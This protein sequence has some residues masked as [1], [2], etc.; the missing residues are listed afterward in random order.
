M[1]TQLGFVVE[2]LA[3]KR[4]GHDLQPRHWIGWRRF[5]EQRPFRKRGVRRGN[6]SAIVREVSEGGGAR[7]S[8]PVGAPL[9]GRRLCSGQK[10]AGP[11]KGT[12]GLARFLVWC[13]R[14]L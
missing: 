12:G 8:S 5:P 10:L 9:D 6:Q 2:E 3:R 14:S 1:R 7:D 4:L 11:R 13:A